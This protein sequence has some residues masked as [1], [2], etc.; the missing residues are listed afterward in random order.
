MDPKELAEKIC[1][2]KDH[3]I[4]LIDEEGLKRQRGLCEALGFDGKKKIDCTLCSSVWQTKEEL[5]RKM[6]EG[7]SSCEALIDEEGLQ[8][9]RAICEAAGYS[10]P[11]PSDI[12]LCNMN[13][14]S[15]P[16]KIKFGR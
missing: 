6:C 9:Q 8:K 2:G 10:A 7:N 4:S 3:C 15:V 12:T 1:K 13:R 14:K 16:K 5:A 11:N